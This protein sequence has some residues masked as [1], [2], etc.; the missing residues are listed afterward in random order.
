MAGY[1]LDRPGMDVIKYHLAFK[2][3]EILTFEI[4]WMKLEGI[5]LS[6]ISKTQKD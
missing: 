1:F 6:D 2:K 3:N 5:L 4:A